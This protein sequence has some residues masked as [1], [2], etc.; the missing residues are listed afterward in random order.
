MEVDNN[1]VV[2]DLVYDIDT[3]IILDAKTQTKPSSND[4][5]LSNEKL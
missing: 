2:T 5:H 4:K 3:F 1:N